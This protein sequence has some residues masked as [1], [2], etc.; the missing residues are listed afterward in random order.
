MFISIALG[1]LALG[2]LPAAKPV[3]TRQG[4]GEDGGRLYSGQAT[5]F[6]TGLGACGYTDSDNESIVALNQ[7]QYESANYCNRYLI[8]EN[9]QNGASAVARVRDECPGCGYGSLDM[10]PSLFRALSSNTGGL[11]EGVFPIQ[12]SFLPADYSP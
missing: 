7:D 8:V 2:Q 11:D 5:W 1:L 10:S 3:T 9:D 12:W 6:Y 4:V